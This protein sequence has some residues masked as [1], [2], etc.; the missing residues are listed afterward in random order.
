MG[1]RGRDG[2]REWVGKGV[3]RARLGYLS[4]GPRVPSYTTARTWPI[5]VRERPR[6]GRYC[7]IRRWGRRSGRS[8]DRHQRTLGCDVRPRGR[9]CRLNTSTPFTDHC[10]AYESTK[11]KTG[12]KL[13]TQNL[14]VESRP[15]QE[16]RVRPDH[17]SFWTNWPLTLM[18]VWVIA[19]ARRGWKSRSLAKVKG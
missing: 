19:I 7:P 4:R 3:G 13:L 8:G 18:C 16:G 9:S 12:S 2:K 11:H 1:R 6:T 17:S 5:L 10:R 15:G 14:V